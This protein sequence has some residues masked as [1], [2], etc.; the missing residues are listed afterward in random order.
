MESNTVEELDTLQED[1]KVAMK[2]TK[3]DTGLFPYT[4]SR[5]LDEKTAQHAI[6]YIAVLTAKY[7]FQIRYAMARPL[8]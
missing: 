6:D 1:T 8:W 7:P 2:W 4:H 3:A 5:S